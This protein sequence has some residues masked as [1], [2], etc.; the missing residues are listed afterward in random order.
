[1]KISRYIK[2]EKLRIIIVL[3]TLLSM[4][5]LYLAM[6]DRTR[7]ISLEQLHILEQ[8]KLVLRMVLREPYLYVKTRK[9]LY[10]I[11]LEAVDI[12]R[13]GR[14]YPIVM[15]TPLSSI[16][17]EWSLPLLFLTLLVSLLY[18][19]RRRGVSGMAG[20]DI[21]IQN[22]VVKKEES[23]TANPQ[24][25]PIVSGITFR[26]VAGIKDA[27]EELTEIIEFLRHPG[28]FMKLGIR[29][30]KGVLLIGPPGVGKT[31]IAKAVAGEAGV[32]FFYQSGAGF[33]HIYVGM[34][35][36]RVHELF[37]VAKRSAPSII[38]IDEIDAV[39]K[40]RGEFGNDE[41]EATLNQLLTEMDGFE[42]DSGVIVIGATNRMDALDEA[43][44]RPG[45]FDRRV[46]ISLPDRDERR[47]ILSLY[48]KNKNSSVNLDRLSAMT[49]GFSSA[50]LSTL[51][52]EA[53]LHAMRR[54]GSI[55]EDIDF[56]A[57]REKVLSGR[58]KILSY[59]DEE[60]E[61]QAVYQAGKA[62]VA[63]WLD[64]EY[65]KI[66]IA[67]TLMSDKE[68]EILSESS[69]MNLLKVYLAGSATTQIV[70]SERFTNSAE[71]ISMARALAYRMVEEM[72]FDNP[73]TAE[74]S[75]EELMTEAYGDVEEMLRKLEEVRRKITAY[76]LE[77]ESI[78]ISETRRILREIF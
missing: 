50:A 45:R 42:S 8:K 20:E 75:A 72:R 53:A 40:S 12:E 77:N 4:V 2:P 54:R 35:A 14:H 52:N 70:Y 41:R 24:I 23:S 68:R 49:V 28:R 7:T 67:E 18:L 19:M 34:G 37:Q 27:R 15:E 10:K 33:V 31:H 32:P 48:L 78:D 21:Q 74:R 44:L 56:D 69:M 38:F 57:V 58:R 3:L 39:G 65:D 43:L 55:I 59:S 71:D 62:L 76:L 9:S 47:D 30:P 26:D 66:G 1:M 61:I 25:Q 13:E 29:L 46:H 16:V 51:V 64:V 73:R 22:G 11:P 63:T 60:R 36:A 17:R 6:R 5:A